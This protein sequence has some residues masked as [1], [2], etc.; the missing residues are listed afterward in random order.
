MNAD[1]FEHKETTDTVLRG[2]SEAYNEA[3]LG[4]LEPVH[5]NAVYAVLTGYGLKTEKPTD[6]PVFFGG[7]IIRA[8][9][10]D[11]LADEKVIVETK[12]AHTLDSAVKDSC[13][14]LPKARGQKVRSRP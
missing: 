10:A 13:R 7:Y 3:G 1:E 2:F 5:E 4:F 11:S 14:T 12:E 8:I 9:K 6:I